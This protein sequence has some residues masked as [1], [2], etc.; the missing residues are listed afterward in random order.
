MS[1]TNYPSRHTWPRLPSPDIDASVREITRAEGAWRSGV[2]DVSGYKGPV[3]SGR[4][5]VERLRRERASFG[6]LRETVERRCPMGF[7]WHNC[8][9]GW[10]CAGGSHDVSDSESKK[11]FSYD[12]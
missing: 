11:S 1:V 10:R 7:A 8:G 5:S 12:T 2:T 3:H 9:S 4:G 6:C